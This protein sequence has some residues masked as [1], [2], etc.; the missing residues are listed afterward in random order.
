MPSRR[1]APLAGLALGLLLDP[2]FAEENTVEL[3][4]ISVTTDAYESATGPVKGYRATRSASA[5]KTDTALRD[6]PQSISVIPATVL[7]DLGSTNVE[8]ALEFAGGVSKQNNFG[9]LTLYEYSVRGFTT[10]EFYQDGFSANR[11]Y[12]STPDAANI[13]RIEV[14]KGPAASLYG[15]GD[16][17]GTVNIV[18]KRPQPEAFTTVQT[19]AGSWDRY[20]TAVDVNTPLDGEGNV[21]SRVNLAVEDNHSFRDH[22]QSKR[23]FVAPSFSW[24]LDPDTR[25]LVESEFVRHSSTFD[26][27]VVDAPGVSRST[28]L[29]EP[30]DGDIDN[31]NNRIQ[32]T[33]EHHLNDAWK[34]RLA[35]HYKQGS[36][37]G[38]ASENRA[39]NVDGHTLDRRYRERSMGWHDSITQLELRGLFDIGS[40]QHELLIGTEYEDYRKK[41]RVTAIGGSRYPIDLYNPV[42]GQPK[43]NGTRSGTD[44]F[45]QTKSQA[46]NL[47]DQ[48]IFTDRLRG[49][50]GA[51]F[52]HFEQSTDDFARNHAK[53]RQTHDALT[54]R[55]GLLYQLTPQVGVFANASTSFKPNSGLDANGKTFKPEEGVGY[56]VGIKSEL[57]DDRLSA[58][59]A[60]FHIEK[61]NVLA[62]DP[63]TNTS[64]A[65]GKARSQGFDLQLT[66]QVT[67]A[68]RVIGAFAYI[69]AEVTK[70]D[71][72]IPAGSRI[73]G[74]AKRSGSLLG[75]Y[76]FQDG[77]LR[78]SDLGAAFTYVGDRSGEAGTRFELPAY[79]TVDLLAHYKATQNVTVGLNLNN[80]FDEKYYERSYSNYWINPGEPRNLTVSL[81]L[82]L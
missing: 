57:F 62:L 20:R 37:W 24:Q 44:F 13:E 27:G 49:M 74:V 9:G 51:R 25:L 6:I 3:D 43:P 17:G 54:Q 70:G 65:M 64:R 29:G 60:A 75:V 35:S 82:S 40:W 52:E 69:D 8:R 16:P 2:A 68:V 7:K 59:L 71:K 14:L 34:L 31:H 26:R 56:E 21:L 42:Y 80:L 61:E 33:L 45:E 19:S 11:G 50:V 32:A 28:F 66:G 73:L 39:L 12:P 38:D 77:V 30:N 47:Q 36:L 63:A 10:S 5:T 46:L 15:R 81:T 53:S 67:E 72:A 58:T 41:E 18:T 76:E 55:A 4:T 79:H 23:V 78:G 1:I 22:V 48:I